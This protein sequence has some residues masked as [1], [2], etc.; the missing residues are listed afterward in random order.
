MGKASVFELL[1]EPGLHEGHRLACER[2]EVDGLPGAVVPDGHP[3]I[4]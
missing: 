4:R 1:R 2:I 3:T